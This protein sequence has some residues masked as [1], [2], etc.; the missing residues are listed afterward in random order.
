LAHALEEVPFTLY[1]NSGGVVTTFEPESSDTSLEIDISE[2]CDSAAVLRSLLN[3]AIDI[4]VNISRIDDVIWSNK[5]AEVPEG[6]GLESH[7]EESQS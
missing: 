2:A 3:T 5:S 7:G 4:A 6:V 1:H